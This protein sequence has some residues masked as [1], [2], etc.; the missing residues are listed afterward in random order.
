MERR[1]GL[2]CLRLKFSSEMNDLNKERRSQKSRARTLKLFAI[3]GLSTST[4]STGE[5]AALE[6]ELRD[7]TVEAGALIAISIL[8]G[9]KFAEIASCLGN[10]VVI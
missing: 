10:D 1:P 9:G 2:L 8:A 5:V 7:Y 3:D 4:V 6:H